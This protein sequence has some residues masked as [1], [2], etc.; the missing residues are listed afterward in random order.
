MDA[1]DQIF[2]TKEE[3]IIL[4]T[5]LR[6]TAET[7]KKVEEGFNYIRSMTEKKFKGNVEFK[8]KIDTL[9]DHISILSYQ[10]K[11]L[12]IVTDSI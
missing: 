10:I 3:V 9:S 2:L 8:H 1:K 7:I 11:L 12:R 5:K 6:G 4:D